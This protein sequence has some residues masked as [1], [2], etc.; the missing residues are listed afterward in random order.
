MPK[1]ILIIVL[2]IYTVLMAGDCMDYL[3]CNYNSSATPI[4]IVSHGMLQV[5]LAV[6]I[7]LNII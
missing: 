1:N 4:N 7:L 2:F 6:F 5:Y 3:A